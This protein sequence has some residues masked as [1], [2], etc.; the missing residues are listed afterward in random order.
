MDWPNMRS[1]VWSNKHDMGT[2]IHLKLD[3]VLL[4]ENRLDFYPNTEPCFKWD[5]IS[6]HSYCDVKSNKIGNVGFK[7]FRYCNHWSFHIGFKD[8]GLSYW[9][10][11]LNSISINDIVKNLM[12]VKHVLKRFNKEDIGDAM[13]KF[14]QSKEAF[15]TAQENLACDP[16]NFTLSFMG[17]KST[18]TQRIDVHCLKQ[19]KCLNLEQQVRLIRPFTRK[20]VK[21]AM[22]GIN[23]LK[24]PSLDGFGFEFFK[25]LWKEIGDDVSMAIL[26]FIEEG[27]MLVSLKNSV[28]TLILKVQDPKDASD[29]HP[30]SCCNTLY[31]CISKMICNRLV[32]VLPKLVF[33]DLCQEL[34]MDLKD[35]D[36][37]SSAQKL[38][39]KTVTL[40]QTV[41]RAC[42]LF[43]RK[44]SKTRKQTPKLGMKAS[45][46]AATVGADTDV[47]QKE[48]AG[49]NSVQDVEIEVVV[50]KSRLRIFK[51]LKIGL[52]WAK[53]FVNN[54]W[55]EQYWNTEA[56]FRWGI[57]SDHCYYLIKHVKVDRNCKRPF[58]FCNHWSYMEGYKE[59]VLNVWKSSN[60]ADLNS[61][62][63]TLFRVKHVLK[64]LYVSKK[65]DVKNCYSEA[66]ESFIRAQEDLAKKP[67]LPLLM[68]AKKKSHLDFLAT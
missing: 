23:S 62:S 37:G 57:L 34:E 19:G 28:I 12:R 64:N 21:K 56:S 16:N 68:Q 2:I 20:D 53:V 46:G 54:H 24:N 36:E 4:N 1:T 27:S 47:G 63:K 8:R 43:G 30:I 55:L 9:N 25:C 60:V 31:K 48:D 61:L 58:R 50:D 33:L 66:K 22:F 42:R 29:F 40:L 65:E 35:L 14:K 38:N 6:D 45:R 39:S 18:T 10:R 11:P 5:C 13:L 67:T 41:T 44:N 52:Q 15:I 51:M 59:V 17:K 26:T 3:R 7:P 49:V 32:E